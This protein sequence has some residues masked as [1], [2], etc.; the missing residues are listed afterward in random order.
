MS[1][2]VDL[3]YQALEAEPD[4]VALAWDGGSLTYRE[5]AQ[6]IS[7]IA[8]ALRAE[9]LREGDGVAMLST[10][11]PESFLL[12]MG[13]LTAGCRYTPLHPLGSSEDHNAVLRRAEVSALLYEAQVYGD[14]VTALDDLPGLVWRGGEF[15]YADRPTTRPDVDISADDL[16]F[17]PFTGGTTGLPKGVMLPHR[18]L[19]ANAL[20]TLAG[21][22]IPAEPRFL[23][24]TPVSHATG[25]ILLPILL[26]GGTVVL[27]HKFDLD[28]FARDVADHRPNMT[29]LVPTILYTLLD[30][31]VDL[32]GFE[33]I[34]YGA[35][36][37][38]PSRL[39]EAIDRFGPIFMQLYAQTEAPNT[40]T[41]L[42]RA[43]HTTGNLTSCGRPLPGNT[44]KLLDTDGAEVP[45]GQVGEICV[46]GPLVMDGYWKEPALTAEAL[47]DGWL[48]TGD[49]ARRDERGFITIVDRAKDMVVTGGFNVYSREV[50]DVLVQHPAVAQAAVIGVP[51]P[52]WGE[53]ITA[54]VVKSGQVTAEEL[55][56]LVKE[57][58]GSVHAPKRVEFVQALPLTPLAKPDKK[59]LRARYWSGS[60]RQVG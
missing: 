50:E 16:A 44:V 37:A 7:Q 8:H 27:Q 10:N 57:H 48:H 56:A 39:A 59:Q 32:S 60:T 24:V 47:R 34:V 36:P 26:R 30:A 9:G 4:A 31:G 38:S 29:F 20:M 25:L 28:A 58:K 33:T 17:L 53:A 2:Y 19:V 55:I 40:L 18:V 11:H 6:R 12:M 43:D 13:A 5:T 35:A 54:V 3:L 23:A 51:D 15:A 49:L 41:V 21:W 46:R 1:T 52:K 14:H 22:D 45:A 42:R